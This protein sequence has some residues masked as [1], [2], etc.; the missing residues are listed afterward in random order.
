MKEDIFFRQ[1][2][3]GIDSQQAKE[4]PSPATADEGA[5]QSGEEPNMEL[6]DHWRTLR[7]NIQ[8]HLEGD[9][10]QKQF[11]ERVKTFNEML[12]PGLV[13][14]YH[15]IVS[16]FK[17]KSGVSDAHPQRE[18]ID[19]EDQKLSEQID[20]WI[21]RLCAE[22]S[23]KSK[24]IG[25]EDFD[26]LRAECW[27]FFESMSSV[28]NTRSFVAD[29]ESYYKNKKS[30]T[31]DPEKSKQELRKELMERY[32]FDRR[33]TDFL[34]DWVRIKSGGGEQ[35]SMKIL[36]E[37]LGRVWKD[38]QV[39]EE[40]GKLGKVSL[41]YLISRGI[42]G[43]SPSLFSNIL[44]D[45][46]FRSSVFLQFLGL[47]QAARFINQ[48]TSVEFERVLT[49]IKHKIN[50][51]IVSSL[52]FR[53]FEFIHERSMG[54]IYVSLD[55]GKNSSINL[56]GNA[57]DNLVPSAFGVGVSLTFLTLI[58]PVLGAIGLG[59]LPVM[60]YVSHKTNKK[61]LA[62]HN[63]E[64]GLGEEIE[65]EIEAIKIGMEEVKTSSKTPLIA[66]GFRDKLNQ[67]DDISL[68]KNIKSITSNWWRRFPFDV[69]MMISG[70]VGGAMQSRGMISGGAILSNV[71][72]SQ[73][74][75]Q[76]ITDLVN[77]YFNR[78]SKD[79]Q[80]I[81]RMEEILGNY[82]T[83]DLP[84]GEKEKSRVPVSGL[85]N[86]DI[87]IKNL[88]YKNILR[89]VNLE[90]K[91]G[92]F[93][94]LV[95]ISGGGKSTLLRNIV[96][97][98]QPDDGAVEV[99]GVKNSEIK[100]YGSES[101]YSIMSYCNQ[102]PQIFENK[103]LRE[104]LVLWSEEEVPEEK[105]IQVLNDLGLSKLISRLNDRA[106]N[107]SGGE[108]VRIGLARTL[109]K[110]AKVL[111]LDEPTA[112]LDSENTAEVVKVIKKLRENYPEMTIVCITHD[113]VLK[114]EISHLVDI[115]DLQSK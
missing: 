71:I 74:L 81:K 30:E 88:T 46:E 35:Y 67:R 32:D 57:V 41:G 85:P 95:G 42:E 100:K 103:T 5:Q 65:T 62:L 101:I 70:L 87:S 12:S 7:Y 11:V 9:K 60:A 92:D 96:G 114:N 79:V 63:Q 8:E 22:L 112:S 2:Q 69:S 77:L 64:R 115:K 68:L 29:I 21:D 84:D 40:K 55:S 109:L 37:T 1:I 4:A 105:I 48:K 6:K 113:E 39:S 13:A 94:G 16:V 91:Q 61:I 82:E 93:L 80:N 24:E 75:N 33:E 76:P 38:Y 53:E 23:E 45:N 59:S 10:E 90:I 47:N 31:G 34:I 28:M 52:F 26:G 15:A 111:L 25:P 108:R 27:M 3:Q 78:F 18:L 20:L 19:L 104:N 14:E 54:E 97:L 83:L 43:F 98:Y 51:R 56:L 36:M 73:Q 110:G 58:H 106:I 44:V 89:G 102:S 99:G 50:E 66:D 17:Q 72:Y 86:F 49:E 107:L